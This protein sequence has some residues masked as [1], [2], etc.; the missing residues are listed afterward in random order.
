M[1]LVANPTSKLQDVATHVGV[2]YSVL[3]RLAAL[4]LLDAALNAQLAA[5][6]SNDAKTD[7]ALMLAETASKRR[8]VVAISTEVVN[9]LFDIVKAGAE[10]ATR[11]FRPVHDDKGL[12]DDESLNVPTEK[13]FLTAASI[14][15]RLG[16]K[17]LTMHEAR[18]LGVE[19]DG[20]V[21]ANPSGIVRI[22]LEGFEPA[23]TVRR[24]DDADVVDVN[25]TEKIEG[26]A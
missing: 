22:V 23:P 15:T 20:V 21:D 2:S 8:D 19:A 7:V 11:G 3:Q 17:F 14:L 5:L 24:F 12:V 6:D 26:A 13:S 25:A 18:A 10:S 9:I 1:Y 4:G 16:E